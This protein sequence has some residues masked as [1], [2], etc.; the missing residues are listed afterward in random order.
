MLTL[1]EGGF[2][3]PIEDGL[4]DAIRAATGRSKK[5]YLIVP[6]QETVNA[7]CRMSEIL[8]PDAPLYFEVTNFT[9]FTNTA[10]REIGGISGEY[11]SGA[12][13]SLL[14]W[15]ALTEL[16]PFLA[17]TRGRKNVSKGLVGKAMSAVGEMQSL[18]ITPDMISCIGGDKAG[19]RRLAEKLSDLSMIYTLYTKLLGEKYSDTANDAAAL[20]AMLAKDGSFLSETEIFVHGFTSFTDGQ[21]KLLGAIMR[22]APLYVTLTVG[23]GGEAFEYSETLGTRRRLIALASGAE[24]EVGLKK[25]GTRDDE[26]NPV[27]GEICDLLWRSEGKIDNSGLQLLYKNDG[28]VRIYRGET[29]YEECDFLA[30][31]IKRR[32]MAG[33][34]YSDIA[35]VAKNTDSY[36]G[37]LDTALETAGVPYFVSRTADVGSVPLFKLIS[38]AYKLISTGY[39][40]E[41][42]L[43]YLKCGLTGVS[44]DEADRFELYIEKW[45]ID[46]RRYTDGIEWNMSPSGYDRPKEGDGELLLEINATRAKLIEPLML[47]EENVRNAVT[48][49]DH[50]VALL[51]FLAAIGAEEAMAQRTEHLSEMGE[52]EE[53]ELSRRAWGIL[54]DALDAL[55]DILGEVSADAVSFSSQLDA[56]LSGATVGR[57]PAFSDAVTIGSADMIRVNGK[58]HIYMLGV[59]AGEFPSGVSEGSYFAESERIILMGLGLP[60]EPELELN[61]ARE[62]YSF[63]RAFASA[64]ESV[65]LLYADKTAMLTPLA[66]AEVIG[67]IKEITDGALTPI[68]IGALPGMD[69][70]YSAPKTLEALH[71]LDG[72]VQADARR[73]LVMSGWGERVAIAEGDI[74]NADLK[75]DRDSLALIYNKDLYLSQTRIDKFLGCPMSYFCKYGLGLGEEKKAELGSNIIGSFVH[76]VI[77]N[78]FG[79]LESSGLNAA[80][81]DDKV[82]DEITRRAATGYANDLLGASHSS[83]RTK[84]AISRLIR[85]TRP[86]VDGLCEELADCRYKPTFFELETN[87][88]DSSPPDHITIPRE[89]GGRIILRGTIDRVDTYKNGDDVYVRVLDYKT[90]YTDFLPSKLGDGEYLQMFLYLKAISDTKKPDFLKRLGVGE[91]GKVIPAGVIYVKSRVQDTTVRT[92]SDEEAATAAKRLQERDGMLLDDPISIDAMNASYIPPDKKR[93]EPLRYTPEGWGEI[94]RTLTEVTRSV[95]D[96]ITSGNIKATPATKGG[97]N[98]K[99]CKYKEICRSAV[100]RNDF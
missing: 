37:V 44:R 56:A 76:A 1:F 9:R 97:R 25:F 98:C 61:G 22:H 93:S 64:K 66:P 51:G 85:A 78:F 87:S 11:C 69:L 63:S 88:Y 74:R 31:D 70:L 80:D 96:G 84:V 33:D 38:I 28:A 40:R 89:G 90:G 45:S 20:A 41:D 77:E 53:S 58:K 47:L 79:E 50:A 57:I 54:C 34:R 13:K 95:A 72:Q 39:R 68:R 71:T 3:S 5:V 35:I 8:P 19:D 67:R 82:R 92:A 29:M 6:E 81:L 91:G 27:I 99:W 73:A 46:G 15:R 2:A 55:V 7:E 42:I 32:V 49:K 30:S 24:C 12:A 94:E 36:L 17:M 43:T 62:L 21:Q 18:G 26:Y 60:I 14:M 52:G 100:I 65:T 48:V 10:F 86:V 23:R 16:S 83:T 59:N 4:I 75:I